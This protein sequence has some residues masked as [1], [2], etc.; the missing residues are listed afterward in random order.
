MYARKWIALLVVLVLGAVASEP[1]LAKRGS[2][3]K[4][5]VS[6]T[7]AA[8]STITVRQ[9]RLKVESRGLERQMMKIEV[10]AAERGADLVVFLE[11]AIGTMD[12]VGT[13]RESRAG[14]YKWRVRTKKGGA[15]P[16]G[17]S[18]VAALSGRHIE[19]RTT[20]GATVGGADVPV[21][22]PTT[23]GDDG[24]NIRIRTG[25]SVDQIETDG[26]DDSVD[27]RIEVRRRKD[28]RQE[29]KVEVD[30]AVAGLSLEAWME[31]AS[32][33]MTRIGVLEEQLSDRGVEYEIERKSDEGGL[34]FGVTDLSDLSGR[35]VEIRDGDGEVLASGFVPSIA[36]SDT[37][38]GLD[39]DNSAGGDEKKTDDNSGS[40]SDDDDGDDDNSGSDSDDDDGDDDN[41]GSDSDDDDGDD[42]NSGSD[43]ADDDGDDD[44]SGS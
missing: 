12:E 39:D 41:S 38:A 42:D 44:N 14:V 30:H 34:P 31:D 1:V 10:K 26:T 3:V 18:D 22:S 25:L 11:D 16:F 27:A 21:I 7:V 37:T 9:A 13:M 19:V 33:V 6:L 36:A 5:R 24:K 32:G 17:V 28:G 43:S 23:A 20:A 40:D 15:L 35:K 29:W 8:D 2:R 4:E